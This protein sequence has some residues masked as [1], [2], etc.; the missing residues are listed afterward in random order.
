MKK[1]FLKNV[2][3]GL[4]DAVPVISTVKE[5]LTDDHLGKGDGEGKLNWT[6][7]ITSIIAAGLIAAFAFGKITLEDVKAILGLL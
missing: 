1:G 6:R 4:V 3:K 2:L 7:L 5:N